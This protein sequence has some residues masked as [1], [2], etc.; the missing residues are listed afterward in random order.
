MFRSAVCCACVVAASAH[1]GPRVAFQP[2]ED[3][4]SGLFCKF[5]HAISAD[6]FVVVGEASRFGAGFQRPSRW[7]F[8]EGFEILSDVPP[9]AFGGHASGISPSGDAIVGHWNGVSGET[10]PF[11]W[12]DSGVTPLPV[13][14]SSGGQVPYAVGDGGAFSV[15]SGWISD[16]F[17]AVGWVDAGLIGPIADRSGV[18]TAISDDGSRVVGA[19]ADSAASNAWFPALIEGGTHRFLF[20]APTEAG[21]A[22]D[23]SADGAVVVGSV[24][25]FGSGRRAFR[26]TEAT[27]PV[28]LGLPS[29]EHNESE[30]WAT[31]DEGD[32]IVGRR[33]EVRGSS[34]IERRAAIW[35]SDGAYHDLADYLEKH[36]VDTLGWTLT[37]CRA[38]SAD[39]RTI[40]GAGIDADRIERAWIAVV[41]HPDAC[42]SADIS[43]PFGRL[44][45]FDLARFLN[46]YAAHHPDGDFASPDGV[47]DFHDVSVFLAELTAGCRRSARRR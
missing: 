39:G 28:L 1:A 44:D 30:A 14:Q 18:G 2:I 35:T 6:G 46:A 10:H 43:R 5:P 23:L 9:S 11:L 21:Y 15:G 4:T 45:F 3:G 12:T 41:P 13:E 42:S 8:A 40:V 31:S 24:G 20:G 17:R 16:Q 34:V 38:V 22:T 32:L 27:G 26:W 36:A 47:F 37:D 33:W 29:G 7:A 19:L 25:L